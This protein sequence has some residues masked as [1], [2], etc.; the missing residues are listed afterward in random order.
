MAAFWRSGRKSG[1]AMA[2][3]ASARSRWFLPSRCAI[4]YSVT[5][6]SAQKLGMVTISPDSSLGTMREIDPCSAVE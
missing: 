4:P 3:R 2:I 1:W 6:V 5:I